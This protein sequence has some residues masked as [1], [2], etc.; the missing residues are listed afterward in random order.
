LDKH[1]RG[2]VL[3]QVLATAKAKHSSLT[4][5]C[6]C[7][8]R[9]PKN[10]AD[11]SRGTC[12]RSAK[13]SLGRGLSVGNIHDPDDD[14]DGIPDQTDICQFIPDPDQADTDGDSVGDACDSCPLISN[15]N[16]TDNDF[17]GLG[18]ACDEDDDNDGMPDEF[19][20]AHGL[21]PLDAADA[22]D[23]DDGDRA[24]NLREYRA[25]TDPQDASSRPAVIEPLLPLL[26]D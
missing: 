26:F 3:G 24:T 23:D 19:E 12:E 21:D 20:I 1:S 16:Q 18:D 22:A 5:Y 17:D 11:R 25:G 8:D 10:A 9:T 7:N 14:N 13:G 15:A 2:K 6:A 4:R